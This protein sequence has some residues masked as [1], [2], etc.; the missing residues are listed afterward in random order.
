MKS[1]RPLLPKDSL[2]QSMALVVLLVLAA[3]GV[4]GP[5]GLLAWGE[6]ARVLEQRQKEIASLTAERD[7]IK[8]RVDLLDP[9]HA[10][11]D[12]VGELL[13]SNLNVTH[14]DDVVMQ[15]KD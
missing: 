15:L 9:R 4:A 10:D 8:N 1:R 5:S 12:L 14:P 7:R 3:V 11:P 2:A 6:N 13:H